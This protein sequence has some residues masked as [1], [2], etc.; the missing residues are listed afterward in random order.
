ME[1]K[2]LL[3]AKLAKILGE[4]GKVEKTGHNAFHKYDYVTENDLV[5]AVRD[6]LSAAG[7]FVFTSTESQTHEIVTSADG[8][9]SLLTTVTTLHTFVDGESGETFAVK[10]QGQGSDNGDKGGY[11]AITG[12]MKYFLYKCFMIPTG[13]DP[14]GDD[15]TDKRT[16]A[17]LSKSS[18]A[19][20]GAAAPAGQTRTE[21][22]RESASVPRDVPDELKERFRGGKWET[23]Q[24]HF[25]K[26]KGVALA[27]LEA[28][29]L[30]WWINEWQPK[31]YKGKFDPKDLELRAA[32]DV[33][34]DE[35][36]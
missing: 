14:E 1:T 34:N 19:P 7:I 15:K 25:G 5:Y 10:S 35:W 8:K 6:K 28:K 17:G 20:T 36:K 22:R 2:N 3:A 24:I 4:V 26:Q 21:E 32:L 30:E 11:K 18:A 12:A 31:E 9:Q 27:Q 16:E 13:D 33:A 23:A 29:S